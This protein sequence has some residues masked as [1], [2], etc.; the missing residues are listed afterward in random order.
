M[1]QAILKQK[2]RTFVTENLGF[3]DC[4]FC[5]IPNKK[6]LARYRSWLKKG[7]QA[8]MEY[9][10]RHLDLKEHPQHLLTN[11]RSAIV[12]IKNYKNTHKKRL[13]ERF[14]IARYA[15]GQDYHPVIMEKL[16]QL[17]VFLKFKEPQIQC[18]SGVDSRP[19]AERNLALLSG[20]GFLGK[21]T[22]VIRPGLGSYF[23]IGVVLTTKGFSPDA[24][25]KRNCGRCRKCIEACPTKA[26]KANSILDTSRCISYRS[27]E[28]KKSY[29]K[30]EA[31]ES[32]GW[33][34][35]CDICQEVCPFN[36]DKV[37]LTDWKEFWP[38]SG[39]GFDFFDHN[40]HRLDQIKIPKDSPLR[41]AKN[42]I[43]ENVRMV[44]S[45]LDNR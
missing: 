43:I 32:Q 9:L 25:L 13:D 11:A 22:M 24:T 33:V 10:K 36:H 35:G 37:P 18:Y 4:R 44:Q 5:H 40:A 30:K 31:R 17:E 15:V 2:I 29:A 34:F 38:Q 8:D 1:G 23:F 6:S 28:R 45:V 7:F 19:L 20:I 27:I 41:R 3:D 39:V 12:V 42:H 26:I 14:K 16:I 21:N